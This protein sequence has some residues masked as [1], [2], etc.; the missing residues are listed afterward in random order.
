MTPY[1][2]PSMLANL[3][4]FGI[5]WASIPVAGA[6][7]A[8]NFSALYDLC[9]VAT[10][11]IDTFC[12]MPLRAVAEVETLDGPDMRLTVRSSNGTALALMQ[13]WP[14]IQ[15]LGAQVTPAG[16]FPRVWS[17]IPASMLDLQEPSQAFLGPSSL[18]S[19]A[20]DGMNGIIIAPGYIDWI[21]GRFGY[22]I[23]I[24]YVN[25]WP[26]GGIMPSASPTGNLA[27]GSTTI[28]NLSSSAG[29]SVGAPIIDIAGAIS[30]GT[31]VTAVATGSLTLSAPATTT[32]VGDLLQVGYAAGATALNVD[33]VT[34]F[35]GTQPM[36]YDGPQVETVTVTA[37]AANSPVQ[38]LPGVLAQAGPGTVTLAS[39]L[40]YAHI[41]ASPAQ[42]L[43]STMP[44]AVRMAAY[45]FAA[46]EAMNRG[47]TQI[48]V[49]A[50]P[51][52]AMSGGK[53]S[54]ASYIEAAVGNPKKGTPGLLTPF[55]RVF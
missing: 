52:S 28:N 31:T 14:I 15:V 4:P 35:G 21:N 32:V 30:P 36:L 9:L 7:P 20:G 29:I 47:T 8:A 34:G 13:H 16:A 12:V 43:L 22:T 49:P 48:A 3:A 37:V 11:S 45:Y 2:L 10:G 40:R 1:V 27:S 24:A 38:L 25:G 19:G 55:I 53:P 18:P 17:S 44:D 51:G 54:I 39:G 33:D 50:L 26:V 42:A 41:G 23:R 46:A 6:S 5:D